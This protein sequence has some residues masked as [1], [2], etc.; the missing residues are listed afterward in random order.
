MTYVKA[1]DL[2]MM[3]D[4]IGRFGG[5][6]VSILLLPCRTAIVVTFLNISVF[7]KTQATNIQRKK[8]L[9]IVLNQSSLI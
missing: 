5:L 6:K 7:R 4:G 9:S 1:L 3:A 2:R 8:T